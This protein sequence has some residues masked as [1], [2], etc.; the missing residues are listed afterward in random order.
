MR[1]PTPGGPPL[2]GNDQYEGY[3]ADLARKI[4]EYAGFDYI[5][6]PAKDAKYGAKLEDN[7]WNGMVGELMRRVC[8]T[9]LY[10]YFIYIIYVPFSA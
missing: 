7:S 6:K 10:Q 4:A 3:C 9:Y 2:V 8:S 1:M 5:I